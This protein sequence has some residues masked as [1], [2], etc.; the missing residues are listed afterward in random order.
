MKVSTIK[1]ASFHPNFRKVVMKGIKQA[2][3]QAISRAQ[4]VQYFYLMPEDFNVQNGMLTP[5]LKLKRGEVLKKYA[6]EIEKM[7]ATSKL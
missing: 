3:Q 4:M 1:E 5:S 6:I 2:N 7:Y